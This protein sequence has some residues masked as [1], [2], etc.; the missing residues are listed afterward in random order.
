MSDDKPKFKRYFII[1]LKILL[2]QLVAVLIGIGITYYYLGHEYSIRE[3]IDIGITTPVLAM[4]LVSF[5]I[6]VVFF[7]LVLIIVGLIWKRV[8]F[9]W[10][11]GA[12][13][14]ALF[15]L[16]VTYLAMYAATH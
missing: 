9:L 6:S 15:W 13:L 3:I 2:I 8:R 10:V 16:Y 11:A 1:L 14:W 5:S 4:R 7:A 12:V